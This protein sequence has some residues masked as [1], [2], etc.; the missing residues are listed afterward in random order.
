MIQILLHMLLL[1]LSEPSASNEEFGSPSVLLS[2]KKRKRQPPEPN[3]S[4]DNLEERLEGFMDKLSVW[5]LTDSLQNLDSNA[6]QRSQVLPN[7]KGKDKQSR[8]LDR[9]QI[10]CEDVVEPLY[11]LH[12]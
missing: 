2:P 1:S 3:L 9:M 4:Y 12:P 7:T 8:G 6:E 10:F 5:Q 11:V